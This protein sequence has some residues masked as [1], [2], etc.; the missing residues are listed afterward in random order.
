MSLVGQGA[1]KK[2]RVV[3]ADDSAVMRRAITRILEAD[4]RIEV[5]ATARDGAEA[6]ELTAK[7]RPDAVT[8]DVNMP[9]IDG[10]R[11]VEI[12]MGRH[13]TPIV[14]ISAHVDSD[15]TVVQRAM[16]RGAVHVIAKPRDLAFAFDPDRQGAEIRAKVREAAH[17]PVIRNANFGMAARERVLKGPLPVLTGT[18]EGPPIVAIG[19]STGGTIAVGE[20]LPLLPGDLPACVLIVQHMPP[21]YTADWAR[22]LDGAAHVTVCEAKH[23]DHLRAGMV[24]VAPG[25]HH[26]EVRDGT[27]RLSAG[28]PVKHHRPSVDVLFDSLRPMASRVIAVLL[29]GMGDDGAAGMVRLRAAGSETV[30]QNEASSVVW[31]MPGAAVKSGCVKRQLPPVETAQFVVKQ[32]QEWTIAHGSTGLVATN[33]RRGRAAYG[34]DEIRRAVQ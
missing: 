8:M 9:R 22:T 6:I 5:V 19:A 31:G 24:L 15:R 4:P 28:P 16:A 1:E 23:G 33:R 18:A 14:V 26:M 10:L 25:G 20:M 11:A 13:P 32:V 3:V 27:V 2:I 21:G 34:A 12:I 30:V 17:V 7:L 29:S